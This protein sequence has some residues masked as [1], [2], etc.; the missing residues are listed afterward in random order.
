MFRS[1]LNG[2]TGCRSG[3]GVSRDDERNYNALADLAKTAS[4]ILLS[5][6]L[7]LPPPDERSLQSHGIPSMKSKATSSYLGQQSQHQSSSRWIQ[8][9]S[10]GLVQPQFDQ[11]KVEP[12]PSAV[13]TNNAKSAGCNFAVGG[14][15]K[16]NM[17]FPLKLMYLLC[18]ESLSNVITW[19][20]HGNAFAVYRPGDLV[21]DVLPT[22]FASNGPVKNDTLHK[23]KPKAKY[24][25]FTRK[26]NR[27]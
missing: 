18:D 23:K 1:D 16:N 8:N 15:S 13:S 27:W 21:N 5:R 26:L 24:A 10:R 12:R 4:S 20:P 25:S 3:H 7:V 14:I 11:K 19:L 17:T 9:V 22:Y 6:V 2:I